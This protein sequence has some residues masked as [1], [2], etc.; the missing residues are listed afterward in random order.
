MSLYLIFDFF[1]TVYYLQTLI[2]T[3]FHSISDNIMSLYLI[4]KSFFF[5]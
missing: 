5:Q 4:C 1:E 3:N 2:N